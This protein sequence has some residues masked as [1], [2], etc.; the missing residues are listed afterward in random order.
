MKLIVCIQDSKMMQTFSNEI[1][2]YSLTNLNK[3]FLFC[4]ILFFGDSARKV[5]LSLM[6]TGI[7]E[8][9]KYVRLLEEVELVNT[10]EYFNVF[11][12][13]QCLYSNNY[14]LI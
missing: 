12:L 8:R 2:N 10:G 4:Y 5:S 6:L 13:V 7:N 14:C 3:S 1:Q 9:S 11:Y